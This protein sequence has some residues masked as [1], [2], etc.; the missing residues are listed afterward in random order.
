MKACKHREG[1][2]LTSV[3]YIW[4]YINNSMTNNVNESETQTQN[5]DFGIHAAL[6][7]QIECDVKQICS[8][9]LKTNL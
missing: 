1:M 7:K 9:I 5:P 6:R 2:V 4:V 3:V 8:L